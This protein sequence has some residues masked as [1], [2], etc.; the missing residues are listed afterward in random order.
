[1]TSLDY[2]RLCYRLLCHRPDRRNIEVWRLGGNS[3]RNRQDVVR[4]FS[5]IICTFG[6]PSEP[7]A[8]PIY[9]AGKIAR[10]IPVNGRI[11]EIS[12]PINF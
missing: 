4:P 7:V 9:L 2:A 11:F 5:D 6:R 10:S 12:K 1:M 3:H 8:E